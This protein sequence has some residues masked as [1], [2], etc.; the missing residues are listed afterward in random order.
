MIIAA[1]DAK[2]NNSSEISEGNA[3]FD[4]TSD[5][6]QTLVENARLRRL[7]ETLY[8]YIPAC[9]ILFPRKTKGQKTNEAR[10]R[11]INIRNFTQFA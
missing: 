6:A 3:L 7:H 10:V 1:F 5:G 11:R 9:P 2:S 8:I 4:E